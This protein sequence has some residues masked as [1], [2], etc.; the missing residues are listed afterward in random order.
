[1]LEAILNAPV[2]QAPGVGLGEE[3]RLIG[4]DVAGA[5][6]IGEDRLAHLMAFRASGL[7]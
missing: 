5:V 7:R 3:Y 1:M 6:L 4:D 2:E